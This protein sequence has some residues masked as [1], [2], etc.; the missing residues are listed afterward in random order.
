M[1]IDGPGRV[2]AVL[3]PEHDLREFRAQRGGH[4]GEHLDRQQVFGDDLIGG[5]IEQDG[6]IGR[7]R[8]AGVTRGVGHLE[9]PPRWTAG[10]ER[11]DEAL[12]SRTA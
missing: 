9:Q 10:G 2:V 4:L 11:D 3:D 5:Q 7:D 12:V 6:A 8:N 1:R